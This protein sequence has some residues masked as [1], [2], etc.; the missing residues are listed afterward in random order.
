MAGWFG[1]GE[2]NN[3]GEGMVRLN[4][5]EMTV[6]VFVCVFVC[7]LLTDLQTDRECQNGTK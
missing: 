6:N 4:T 1:E 3:R 2:G 5:P 7:V